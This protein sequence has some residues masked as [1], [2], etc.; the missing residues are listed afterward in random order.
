MSNVQSPKVAEPASDMV[1]RVAKSESPALSMT[2]SITKFHIRW[3]IGQSR[4]VAKPEKRD[5]AR[6]MNT[7]IYSCGAMRLDVEF[8]DL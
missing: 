8:V 4:K 6:I 2:L 1:R 7:R 5:V 3:I